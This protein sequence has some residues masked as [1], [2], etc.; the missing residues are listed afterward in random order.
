MVLYRTAVYGPPEL[1]NV[2]SASAINVDEMEAAQNLSGAI[3]IK[4]ISH[5][6]EIPPDAKAFDEFHDYLRRTFPA[7]HGELTRETV[8][9]FS[10]LY[11]WEGSDPDL[12]PILYSAHM[13]VVPVEPGTEDEWTHSR[14]S[15]AIA[16]G[17]IWG[18]GSL[19]MK[20]SLIGYMHAAELLIE[21]GF[22]PERTI[23][24][25]VGHDEEVGSHAAKEIAALLTSRGIR[26]YYT[27]DEGLVI[28][29]GIVPGIDKPVALIG[30]AERG[31][32]TLEL[33]ATGPGGHASMPPANPLNT[34]L[35][36]A[37]VAINDNQL[38]AR[39]QAPALQ[40]FELWIGM[41]S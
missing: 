5:S 16:D 30:T 6:R 20:Q 12:D 22:E 34:I 38:P 11:T 15:G 29:N 41:Q 25:A 32:V 27:L 18:R 39:L 19:D 2:P 35:A 13:D 9:V 33:I 3:K 24:F 4:T 8:A 17:F 31:Y 21:Q 23:Y 28:T 36:R 1:I 10:L 37:L 7:G 14:F 26:L 40:M